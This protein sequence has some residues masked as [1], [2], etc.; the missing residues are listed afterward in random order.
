MRLT[1]ALIM[2]VFLLSC[3]WV[4]AQA[5]FANGPLPPVPIPFDN[6]Q[7]DA[8]IRLG[9]QLLQKSPTSAVCSLRAK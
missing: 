4:M 5:M 6:P 8:K 3:G 2:L 9:R 1:T 7:T